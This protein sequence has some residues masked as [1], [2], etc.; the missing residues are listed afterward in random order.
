MFNDSF[1]RD[2]QLIKAN[3]RASRY[4][5]V[6]L[7]VR[8]PLESRRLQSRPMWHASSRAE[9]CS[10]RARK[11]LLHTE[12]TGSDPWTLPEV[13]QTKSSSASLHTVH[14]GGSNRGCRSWGIAVDR[15]VCCS[16]GGS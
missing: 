8:D 13:V 11:Q 14:R 15:G 10:V 1:H 3:P 12:H 5:A 4:L 9:I 7:L 16:G 2:F 6:G